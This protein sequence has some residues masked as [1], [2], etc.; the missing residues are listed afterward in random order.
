MKTNSSGKPGNGNN[1]HRSDG[2]A[3]GTSSSGRKSSRGNGDGRL[4][5]QDLDRFREMLLAKRAQLVGDMDHMKDDAL[6]RSRTD[7]AGDLSCMPIHMADI[8]SDNYE[9]EFTLGLIENEQ[10]VLREIDEALARLD[11]GTF[12]MCLGT[13]KP[14]GKARLK[15][16]P[17]A[18]YSIEYVRQLEAKN[19]D[20]YRVGRGLR[21]RIGRTIHEDHTRL[22]R[23]RP[24]RRPL[25]GGPR[26]FLE[27][28]RRGRRAGPGHEG[29][30]IRLRTGV[31][32]D[33]D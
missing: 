32:R 10:N 1:R 8:G 23:D 7:A 24:I 3:E 16:K 30:G 14:I 12:G 27:F 15:L 31:G 13:G 29:V 17:W 22:P 2:S 20:R 4:T 11:N 33:H 9:Q 5:P 18:K 19:K 25:A 21:R 28:D 6:H 26:F